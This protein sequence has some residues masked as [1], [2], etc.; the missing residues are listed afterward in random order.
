MSV[1]NS[2]KKNL[3]LF[4]KPTHGCRYWSENFNKKV[5]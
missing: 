4:K 5:E 2:P 3:P 1:T